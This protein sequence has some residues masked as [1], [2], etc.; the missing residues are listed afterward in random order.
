MSHVT[1][2]RA[3]LLEQREEQRRYKDALRDYGHFDDDVEHFTISAPNHEAEAVIR[4]AV[5]A[6][7]LKA[8][9]RGTLDTFITERAIRVVG[10][11]VKEL[12]WGNPQKRI[13]EELRA[14]NPTSGKH[15]DYDDLRPLFELLVLADIFADDLETPTEK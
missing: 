12:Y 2:R 10:S 13:V 11:A 15:V 8:E 5:E 1:S 6:A 14:A 3:T 9:P 7:L 4:R